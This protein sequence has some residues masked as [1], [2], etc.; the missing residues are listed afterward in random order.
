MLKFFTWLPSFDDL[1]KHKDRGVD[2]IVVNQR[3][4]N[5]TFAQFQRQCKDLN[6]DF[7]RYPDPNLDPP[8][9]EVTDKPAGLT[10]LDEPVLHG[11]SPEQWKAQRDSFQDFVRRM[12]NVS[13]PLL[14][15]LEGDKFAR[16]LSTF[17][18]NEIQTLKDYFAVPTH[19]LC[20]FYGFSRVR[21]NPDKTFLDWYTNKPLFKAFANM[22]ALAPK[23]TILGVTIEAANQRLDPLS[24]APTVQ[25]FRE[26]LWVPFLM[27]AKVFMIFTQSPG[28][29]LPTYETYG[30][31]NDAMPPELELEFRLNKPRLLEVESW[32]MWDSR[33]ETGGASTF[34][35]NNGRVLVFDKAIY[36]VTASLGGLKIWSLTNQS[37]FRKFSVAIAPDQ[38]F[39]IEA[40]TNLVNQSTLTVVMKENAVLKQQIKDVLTILGVSK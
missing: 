39:A 20:D 37:N 4:I 8:V 24:R 17:R 38:M 32:G 12:G 10:L 34:R 7:W 29:K 9:T 31:S 1:Q 27:G 30:N 22:V 36:T 5:G 16:D 14:G 18:P 21:Y 13:L 25:E 19:L 33:D 23:T 15:N 28:G 6:L 2:G 40:I 11:W 35:W 26:S 3:L